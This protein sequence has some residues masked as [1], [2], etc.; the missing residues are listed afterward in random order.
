MKQKWILLIYKVPSEPSRKRAYVWRH[1]KQLGA[2]YLQ[3]AVCLLPNQ[4]ELEAPL[5]KLADKILEFEGEATVFYA[6]GKDESWNEKVVADFQGARDAEYAEVIENI[7]H[8]EREIERESAAQKFT[9]AELE[10]VESD[11]E[12]ISKWFER[13]QARDYF[14]A[15]LGSQAHE[16]LKKAQTLLE[17]FAQ[18]VYL[19]EEVETTGGSG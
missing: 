15:P 16:H 3:Q 14:K 1:L 19:Q 17:S 10:D 4:P 11:M 8:F 2:I 7:E 12:K 6:D 9:F 5:H 13:V 18:Q